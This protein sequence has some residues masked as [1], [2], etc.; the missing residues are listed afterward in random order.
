ME[1]TIPSF[2]LSEE[3]M[4]KLQS[5]GRLIKLACDV[6]TRKIK[7]GDALSQLGITSDT[8]IDKIQAMLKNSENGFLNSLSE[9][10]FSEKLVG[11]TKDI[12][13]VLHGYINGTFSMEECAEQLFTDTL[14]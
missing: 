8:L 10:A 4:E 9:T 14:Q 5:A 2:G 12:A 6:Y 11:T 13:A 1:M 3:S 7:L